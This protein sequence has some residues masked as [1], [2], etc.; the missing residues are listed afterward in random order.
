MIFQIPY[1][2]ALQRC[3]MGK[4]VPRSTSYDPTI[5]VKPCAGAGMSQSR[6]S[7]DNI[8]LL[9]RALSLCT[10]RTNDKLLQLVA[11]D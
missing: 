3:K 2:L 8:R 6:N 5:D 1:C 4:G 7:L 11:F 9:P 10:I